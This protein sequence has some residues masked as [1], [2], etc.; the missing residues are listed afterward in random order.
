MLRRSTIITFVLVFLCVTTAYT[1]Q[2]AAQ[3]VKRVVIV[4]IDGLPG[5]YVDRFVKERDPKTGRTVLPWFDEIFYKNGSRVA[6]FY[7]HGMSLSGPSWSQLDTGQHL[8]IKG[9]VEFDRYTMHAYDYL[10]FFPYYVQYGLKKKMDMPAVE[11]LDQLEIPLLYDAFPYEKRYTSHQLFQRGNNWEVLASGFLNLYPG[12]PGDFIDEWTMGLDFRKTT[13][14]QI[15]RDIISKVSKRPEIDYFDYYDVSFDHMSHHNNDTASRLV[16]LKDLDRTLGRIWSAIQLSPRADETALVLV[17]DHGFNSDPKVYS[18]GFNIVNLLASSAGGGHHIVTKRRLMLDYTIKGV[19]PLVPLIRTPSENSYYLKGQHS[20]YPTVIIDFDGNER[21]SLHLRNADLNK[22]HILLQ[23]L[24]R[25]K[26][27]GELR[28]GATRSFFEIIEKNRFQW[29]DTYDQLSDELD[30]LRQWTE[31]Q[32]KIVST[33]PVKYSSDDI[34]KGVDKEDRRIAALVAIDVA[35][36]SD[37][38]TYLATLGNLLALKRDSFDARKAKIEDLIAP[39]AMG[40]LN[41]LYELQNYPVGLSRAGLILKADQDLDLDRS[42]TRVN[43]F[44]LLQA[45]RVRNNVQPSVANRPVDFTAVRIPYAAI[46]EALPEHIAA[47]EDLVWVYAGAQNQAL[48]LSRVDRAGGRSFFYLPVARL[49]Q[50][51]DGRITFRPGEWRAGLPLKYFED[52]NLGIPPAERLAWLNEW[53]TEHEWLRAIHK[54]RYS[55]G[56]IGLNEQLGRK[57][58]FEAQDGGIPELQRLIRRFRERQRILSE[59]DLLVM[60]NDHW[61]FDVKGFNAGGNH[62]SFFRVSTNATFMLAGG[63]KTNIPRGLVVEEP[64]DSLSFVP[65]VLRLMGKVDDENRPVDELQ[66]IGFRKFPG[67]IVKEVVATSR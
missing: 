65:T 18:Q 7:T 41:S 67:R 9:N 13:I 8:Q 24:Q 64:Y 33:H 6:N 22:L 38:R 66:S 15:E 47:N 58:I 29:Q 53:H 12:N 31:A 35:A 42:F 37:Y 26:L 4:K 17:S 19:Y 48:I 43:Y 40:D 20:D 60:A 3:G 56:L 51:A 36:E 1:G 30:A 27:S 45:Q 44:E 63:A 25:T 57:P 59:T 54:A 34:S 5:Y 2:A 11:V 32:Q 50:D 55:N 28:A 49:S 16:V 46:S 23:Q 52:E 61:N 21:S 10:N 62:G 14:N 39:G